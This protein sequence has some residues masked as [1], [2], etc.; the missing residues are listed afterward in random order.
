MQVF[1][2][3]GEIGRKALSL[4]RGGGLDIDFF[5][6][7]NPNMYGQVI[8]HIK[9]I[10]A[11][12]L[13][14]LPKDTEIFAT[15]KEAEKVA[16]QLIKLGISGDRIT[17]C[18]TTPSVMK[19]VMGQPEW[20]P[21]FNKTDFF[22]DK[23]TSKVIFELSNGLSMGGV[24]T[25]SIQTSNTLK[26]AGYSTAILVDP[27]KV[28]EQTLREDML[29]PIE[30]YEDMTEWDRLR[31]LVSLIINAKNTVI[32]C[33]FI[34]YNFIAACLAKR[35]FPDKI[36]VITVIHND[37]EVYFQNYVM[38]QDYIDICLVIS[39]RIRSKL[40]DRQFPK[41][42]IVYLPWEIHCEKELKRS[43]SS[44]EEPIRIGY[45]GRIVVSQKRVDNLVEV[46][47]ILKKQGIRFTMEIAGVGSHEKNLKQEIEEKDLTQY[48]HLVGMIE[49]SQITMF[50]RR[51]DIMISCSDYEG[52]SITQVEAM[53]QGVVPVITDT[54][55]ARDDVKDGE[56]GFVVDVGAVDQIAYRI[57]YLYN[58]R[59][60]IS[61][62]GQMAYMTIKQKNNTSELE[63]IWN[64]ILVK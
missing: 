39:E 8:E 28:Q 35:V 32:V 19:Y 12:Q 42:K 4:F 43:Y 10:S 44:C 60:K 22:S 59:D 56:N 24:E 15:C 3:A 37:E 17:R 36:K 33:N 50:W 58:H 46:A 16:A 13:L 30:Y 9:V 14:Q 40:I 45:A 7:N 41:E 27:L 48:V 53:S 54:S 11:E 63:K 1:F 34:G 61:E 31:Y 62:M 57:S 26:K 25:W 47:D 51:Q 18:N 64:N 21:S 5:C 29:I 23:E 52:H 38:F 55:G 2:G 6:D 20:K 49:H